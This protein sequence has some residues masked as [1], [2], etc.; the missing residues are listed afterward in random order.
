MPK[1]PPELSARF[2]AMVTRYPE[3]TRRQMFG[4]PA[5]FVGGNLT[6]SLFSDRW[7]IRLPPADLAEILQL[8]DAA[9]FE[10]MPGR[11]MGGYAL[12]PRDVVDDDVA[13]DAWIRRAIAHT[14][15]LPAK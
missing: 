4:Y 2:D 10:P 13:L 15:G 5:L 12:L 6:T 3:A 9:R 1:S 14:S 8:P 11:P 7:V